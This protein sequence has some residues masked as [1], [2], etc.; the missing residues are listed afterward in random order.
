MGLLAEQW[1]T[2]AG[3]ERYEVSD[4]GRVRNVETGRVLALIPHNKGYLKVWLG[5]A[6][7]AYV[8]RLVCEAFHGPPP[9][10]G[11]PYHAD[12]R[13]F[14][15]TDNRASNLRWLPRHLNDFR[16]KGYEEIE[17]PP[18]WVALSPEEEAALDRKL[19]AA[20]W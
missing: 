1:R 15:P 14:R 18:E 4:L 10:D 3:H 17:D 19:E 9:D 2:I 8:H 16:W 6:R 13:N 5:R 11:L 12:H 7:L 20:G